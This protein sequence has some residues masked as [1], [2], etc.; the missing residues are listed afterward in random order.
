VKGGAVKDESGSF[1]QTLAPYSI[2]V[3]DVDL[4]TPL[5][6]ASAPVQ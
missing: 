3:L 6:S 1:V 2:T 4:A 5:A